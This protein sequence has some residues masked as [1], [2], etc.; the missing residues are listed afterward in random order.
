MM[1]ARYLDMF[2]KSDPRLIYF[3]PERTGGG[4]GPAHAEAERY[5][6]TT[7]VSWM[8]AALPAIQTAVRLIARVVGSLRLLGERRYGRR[9]PLRIDCARGLHAMP[10]A[11]F[12]EARLW[13][14]LG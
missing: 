3:A 5:H 10:L 8:Q 7:G 1:Q 11:S 14:Y 2:P 6:H 4:H 13:D 12:S 9:Q